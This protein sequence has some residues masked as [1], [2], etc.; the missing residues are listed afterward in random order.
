M[1]VTHQNVRCENWYSELD[2]TQLDNLFVFVIFRYEILYSD[3]CHTW[4]TVAY[5]TGCL[6]A[7]IS[8]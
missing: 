2:A 7:P 3:H 1:T 8:F 4:I 6:I 5:F